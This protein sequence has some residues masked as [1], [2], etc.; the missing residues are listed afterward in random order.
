MSHTVESV[1]VEVPV[2]KSFTF[3]MEDEVR[4]IYATVAANEEAALAKVVKALPES[5]GGQ[6][7]V[8][9]VAFAFD[10]L[11]CRTFEDGK[12]Q[13]QWIRADD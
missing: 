3:T 6:E 7:D 9:D 2:V 5:D 13:E 10:Y 8:G 1:A 11:D 4:V 12:F